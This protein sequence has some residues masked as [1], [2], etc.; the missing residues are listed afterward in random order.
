[1]NHS[2]SAI[3]LESSVEGGTESPWDGS[4]L[5]GTSLRWNEL[6]H[7]RTATFAT[8]EEAEQYKRGLEAMGFKVD[9]G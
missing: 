6:V 3:V 4:D 2:E 1:M 8:R 9:I 5:A 7:P